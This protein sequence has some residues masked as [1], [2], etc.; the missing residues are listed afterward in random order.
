[1]PLFKPG[2]RPSLTLR[3]TLLF[4]AAS[5]TVLLLL[6]LFIG[7]AVE[8]H[9]VEQDMEQLTGKQELVAQA[10]AREAPS[11]LAERLDGALVGHH[12]L[13]LT[14]LSPA[15]R[16]FYTYGP[17]GEFPAALLAHPVA[18]GTA[19]TPRLWHTR[20]GVAFR[21]F[22]STIPGPDRRPYTLALAL[23][24]RHHDHFMAA[25]QRRLWGFVVVAALIM[26]LA[27][28]AAVGRGLAPLRE[29][30]RKTA[31]I[32]PSRLDQRID[33]QD[34]PPE[35]EA[36]AA[37]LNAMLDRLENAFRR[38]SDFS[39]DLAHELRTPVSNLLTQTQVTLSKARTAAEYR[40]ILASNAEELERLGPIIRDMLFL[41]QADPPPALPRRETVDLGAEVR[42]LCAYYEVLAEDGDITLTVAGQGTVTGDRLMLRR[43]VGNLVSNALHHTPAA[44][45]VGVVLEAAP[46]GGLDLAVHNN[47]A[48][49][50]PEHL[51]RLFDRFYRAAPDRQA[52]GEGAGLGLA[53][54]RAIMAAH[55]GEATVTS[56]PGDT[57]FRLHF[58]PPLTAD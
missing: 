7:R 43:A 57:C 30:R 11:R 41:A 54:T 1:M 8:A 17:A 24:T 35:L 15:G 53:I 55:G 44:G 49:I 40:D 22:A 39:A 2:A 46:D 18:P 38:L 27:G 37:S 4:A 12:G 13:S 50:A 14:L 47:G 25:F 45:R 3:L 36:L 21:G 6:G 10:L 29:I 20:D 48:P 56:V 52:G 33:L 16:P 9:F 23:D 42:S 5:T 26:G 19:P 58:P 32:T 31:A 28:W 51:P 34:V